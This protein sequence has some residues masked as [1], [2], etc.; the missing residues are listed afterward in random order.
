MA[1]LKTRL[2][3]RDIAPGL[4]CVVWLFLAAGRETPVSVERV[5]AVTVHRELAANALTAD[6]LSLSARNVLRRWVLSERYDSDPEGTIA[7]LHTIAVGG[8]GGADEIATL[9]EIAFLYAQ[10]TQKRPYFLATAIYAFAF[11]FPETEFEPPSPYDP[12]LRL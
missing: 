10:K 7:A 2:P 3:G 8:R 1:R 11:L 12:R 6:E 9:A 4:C 5:D